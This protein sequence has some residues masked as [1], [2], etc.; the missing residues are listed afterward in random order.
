[1]K[2]YSS[3]PINQFIPDSE[4]FSNTIRN[5]DQVYVFPNDLA[6]KLAGEEMKQL[7]DFAKK[8]PLKE[9]Q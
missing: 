7:R 5:A 3:D 9:S 8:H 1:M 4:N 2:K 6:N